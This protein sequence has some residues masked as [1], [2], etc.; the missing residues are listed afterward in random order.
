MLPKYLG[1][2][3]DIVKRFWA[4]HLAG[5]APVFAHPNFVPVEIRPE[6]E[7]MVGMPVTD[8]FPERFAVFLDPHTGIPL[9]TSA[10]RGATASHV[11]LSFI[12]DEF[13]RLRPAYMICFDQSYDRRSGL[14]KAQQ[15]DSKR[16]ALRRNQIASFYYVSHA[17]F[18]FMARDKAVLESMRLRLVVSGVPQA[19]LECSEPEN[20]LATPM[21]A[22][23]MP[24]VS[25]R[26]AQSSMS[27]LCPACGQK[28]F[29]R[30]PSGWDAH[31]AH[32]CKGLAATDAE[33]R[34]VEFRNRFADHFHR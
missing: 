13:D 19:R 2:S 20:W 21:A 5:I 10:S 23:T 4:D 27:L 29:K 24:R 3:F 31:A 9:P 15:R 12:V 30:W 1:D 14:S 7:K 17:P 33:E 34:K 6:Y 22:P 18:L 25:G 16:A 26:T 11:S 8:S 32:T 28:E